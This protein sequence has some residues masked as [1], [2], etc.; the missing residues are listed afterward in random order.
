MLDPAPEAHG[1]GPL[2]AGKL[3]GIGAGH[4]VVG[5]LDLPA[6][7]ELLAEHAVLVANSV[8]DAGQAERRHGVEEAGSKAS[9]AAVAQGRV[10]LLLVDLV[11]G[12]AVPGKAR[13]GGV[14]QPQA[15]ERVLQLAPIEELHRQVG[16]LL[17]ALL[18]HARIAAVPVVDHPVA[19]RQS[20]GTEPMLQIGIRACDADV[21]G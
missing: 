8:A 18:A 10:S 11:E 15:I 3:P 19:H 5:L 12:D 21:L 1:I 7:R 20:R 6:V 14:L 16:Y 17:E 13:P 9:Q 4:P 2:R